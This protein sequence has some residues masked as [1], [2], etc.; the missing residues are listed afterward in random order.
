MSI[1]GRGKDKIC[2]RGPI[3]A[4]GPGGLALCLCCGEMVPLK[5]GESCKDIKCPKCETR[6]VRC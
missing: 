2:L 4:V 1:K 3:Y 5:E 6:M